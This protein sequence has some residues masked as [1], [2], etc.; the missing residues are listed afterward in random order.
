MAG[1]LRGRSAATALRILA[2]LVGIFFLALAVDKLT[3]LT[4]SGPLLRQ[5]D[6]W[7]TNGSAASRWYV[8]VIA[9]PGTPLFARLVPLAEGAAGVALMLGFWSRM[10]AGLA[11]VM[12]LNFHFAAGSYWSWPFLRDGMGL[13]VIGALL[14]IA[15]GGAQM[16]WT[17]RS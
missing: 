11:L 16:P 15:I 9:R 12:V 3:W 2:F 5:F 13:P 4:D 1:P 14:A 6:A 7:D 8:Q 17:L 10:V